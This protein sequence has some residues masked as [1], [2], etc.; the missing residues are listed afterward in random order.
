MSFEAKRQGIQ[1]DPFVVT[2][3]LEPGPLWLLQACA[4]CGGN[5]SSQDAHETALQPTWRSSNLPPESEIC[6]KRPYPAQAL[7][8]DAEQ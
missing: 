1:D 4:L 7:A 3:P 5:G 8:E 6:L 2:D